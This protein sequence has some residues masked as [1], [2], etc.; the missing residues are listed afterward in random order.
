MIKITKGLD[1]PISGSPEQKVYD[2]PSVKS[3]ALLGPDYV[4]MKPSMTVKV[5]D[6]VKLG[7]LLFTDK[8]N[9]GVK[10]TS[11]GC[12][13][14]VAINR[15][16]RRVLQSVVIELNG[17]DAEI[18]ASY[19]EAELDGLARDK[20]VANLVDSGLWT[21][22]RTRP[23]S[24]IPAI[25]STPAAI[26]VTAMDTNP[27]AA[28]AELLI[29]EEEQAFAN[30]LKVLS[31][32]TDGKL[33]VCQK[34]NVV[35]PRI[36]GASYEEFDGP[37]P[38]GLPGTHIHFLAP[39]NAA[40]TVWYINYQDVI[41]YGKFFLS[42]K[43]PTGRIVALAGPG[44]SQPRLLRTRMGAN[45]Q[46]LTAGGL[47]QGEQRIVSGSVLHGATA[48]GP[49]AFLGRYH[50]QVSVLPEKRD[51]EFLASLTAGADKFSIKRA[52]LTAFTGGPSGEMNT[53]TYGR[54]GNILDIGSFDKVMPLDILPG[55]LLRALCSG[56]T[57]EAQNLGCLEL[58]EED[59]ALCTFV[60]SG[61]KEYGPLLRSALTTIEKE[62]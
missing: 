59:L 14:V 27:L 35:L 56:D 18:F 36:N 49:L 52:F 2:A 10:F 9:E 47:K 17:D 13:K 1:L 30:G 48:A 62:G 40:K 15:G 32:L 50:L 38:A 37:H 45:L 60:C 61:K 3:V 6:Q 58:D 41:A 43:I 39:V 19:K 29:K 31:R 4:G 28:R 12:G 54:P 42:G 25:D 23:F 20:V 34:P 24:K 16:E 51:R 44:V 26:F 7:Q 57:D 46:E 21:A 22:L 55:F 5:G 53:S 11:P 8:K 33:Y